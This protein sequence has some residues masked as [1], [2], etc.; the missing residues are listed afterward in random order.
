MS[1]KSTIF[2]MRIL[3][4]FL[5]MV[6][7]IGPMGITPV[8]AAGIL[9]V[10]PD[11]SGDCSDWANAC[12]L[13]TALA[14]AVSG[15]E[16][17]VQMGVYK[18][19][20]GTDRTATFQL[21]GGVAVYGGFAG[22]E[23]AR[24]ERNFTV[25]ITTLSGD[26]LGNDNDI[27]LADE[28]TRA[29]NSYHVVTGASGAI[30]DG[31]TVTAGNAN[32]GAF[33]D[34]SGGGFLE[35]YS[36]SILTNI[37]FLRNTTS[38]GGGGMFSL[39]SD[40]IL[41]DITFRED[42]ALSGGGMYSAASNLTIT[43][44]IFD[45]N[46]SAS[47][48]GGMVATQ[49]NLSLTDITFVGNTA[50]MGGGLYNESE[51]VMNNIAF[52]DNSAATYGGGMMDHGHATLTNATFAGNSAQNGGGL[53]NA[54]SNKHEPSILANITFTANAA[55]ADGGGIYNVGY[56]TIRNT[57]LWENTDLSGLQVYD[58]GIA[59][60]SDSVI[61]GECSVYSM[62]SNIITD[63]PLLGTLGYYGGYT[64]TIPIQT[65][66]SAIDATSNNCP[67][68]DQR[69][70]TRSTPACDIGAY[71]AQ[72]S[73]VL[74]A[75]SGGLTSGAC[76]SW[77]EACDLQYALTNAAS[78]Q[79]IW[80]KAGTHKPTSGAD[81]TATFQLK[82]GVAVYGGFNGTESA[83]DQR[84]FGIN[85]TTLSGDLSGN[86]N[87]HVAYNEPTRAD[88]SYH[89]VIG[90]EGATLDGF[91]ITAGNADGATSCPGLGCGGGMVDAANMDLSN[92]IFSKNS[93]NHG[94]AGLLISTGA[95]DLTNVA[96][97]GN[98]VEVDGGGILAIYSSLTL[99]NVTFSGNSA[100]FGGGMCNYFGQPILTNV[101]FSGNSAEVGGGGI[102]NNESSPVLTNVTVSGNTADFGGGLI[103]NNNSAS[104]PH[105]YNSIIWG[106]I[107]N[108]NAQIDNYSGNPSIDDSI[109][110]DGCPT[111]SVCSNIIT[112]NPLLGTTGNYG[113]FTPTTPLLA[114]SSAIDTG[115]DATCAEMDQRGVTRPQG[116]HCDIGAYEAI[117]DTI[118]PETS[119]LSAP[120]AF[121]HDNT[122]TFTFSGDDGLNSGISAFFCSVDGSPYTTCTSPYTLSE[123][124]D[125]PHTFDVYA[126]DLMGN[127][128]ASPASHAWAVDT[129]APETSLLTTPPALDNDNTPTFTF[130][131][132]DGGGS[133]V[134]SFMCKLDND[135]FA[136]C[137]SP[138]TLPALVDG[139]HS[140]EVY[141]LDLAG[142]AD[143]SPATY[144]W[145]IE[146]TSPIVISITRVNPNPTNL[147]S[148]KFTVTF[149]KPVIGVDFSDFSLMATDG[150]NG[151]SVTDVN[152]AGTVYV[153]TVNTG[154]Y[155][156]NSADLINI[157]TATLEQLDSLPGIGPTTAQKIIDYRT[158]HGP[159]QRIEDIMN[160]SD[161]GPSTFEKIKNLI[162]VGLFLRLDVIDDDT[163]MDASNNK[164][165]G[166]GLGN[167]DFISGEYY[168]LT[169]S[170]VFSDVPSMYWAWSFIERLYN[171]GITG[172]CSTSPLMYCPETSVTRAQMAIFLLRGEHGSAYN[173]PDA[174][175][176]IFGDVPLGHWAGPW[177][178]QL[179]AEGIT[180]GCGNGNY[181]PD[182]PVTRDQMAVFLL[183][184]EHG[185]SYA[186]PTPTGV[187]TDVP[188][189][190]WAA[191]W[192]EQLAAEGITGGCGSG[193]YC[194]ATIVNRAQ[195]AVFLVRA[196]NLP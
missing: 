150:I 124:S 167:G 17:W 137:I 191:A 91:T 120:S 63:N 38:M 109:I 105:I 83:R 115:N 168:T 102:I 175:G 128:D 33:P 49:G 141:A 81:R 118:P 82:S 37:L 87:S 149:S 66:S 8:H 161:I 195:M 99:Q 135:P 186:P 94:G 196:F 108:T 184:A 67:A 57:I 101:T 152:G 36:N 92:L 148:V 177:I 174:T 6:L 27:I 47:T 60:I 93:A 129:I 145:N 95:P 41:T 119:I 21:K 86:D 77:A 59:T 78:G 165:G 112:T 19:T 170:P 179:A 46:S 125:G 131:G 158:T 65:G 1:T 123:L 132:N 75:A 155:N 154:T 51:L 89:V 160:V 90:A 189:D 138:L 45:G 74:Y 136:A 55:E 68:T 71:E 121:D 23:S 100:G 30:L 194:P 130:D 111:G 54:V 80:V 26:L 40:A 153:V 166:P 84:D 43:R 32:G 7:A 142:N 9:Y 147:A 3:S 73:D 4:V 56:V 151:A 180:G 16:I 10:T 52:F 42:N 50:D 79:E 159:F 183:R 187:F 104:G 117:E 5:I 140:L 110:Q 178:E 144:S 58:T 169:D 28:P 106:N 157:N 192:I 188:T 114:G 134:A 171:A 176:T 139:P 69:G 173:P 14:N 156:V 182:L 98:V 20:T 64:Q 85:V 133:G 162:T 35:F 44:V 164:L 61:Q 126:I 62:C 146:T 29:D 31:F 122:P 15:D 11:G 34:D 97:I 163:I 172:G 70:I 190:H 107:A 185:A 113:G 127:S 88:N 103:T 116:L 72:P 143:P 181:C 53:G 24:D 193:I 2:T 22:T 12:S 96:F 76:S 39:N 25:N 48:G 18:P 13:Q